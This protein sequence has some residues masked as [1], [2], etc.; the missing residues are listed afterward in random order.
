MPLS[1]GGQRFSSGFGTHAR[2]LIRV[3]LLHPGRV[4]EGGY[5][6]DDEGWKTARV[7]F[8]IRDDHRRVL[9][10]SE[11]I[12]Y[13]AVHRFSVPLTGQRQ[14]LLE[15]LPVGDNNNGAHVDWVE[16]RVK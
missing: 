11:P 5:G 7:R 6:I 13:G 14:L 12:S 9:L 4:F 8:R 3:R 1:I 10:L 15:V 2:S 16:L